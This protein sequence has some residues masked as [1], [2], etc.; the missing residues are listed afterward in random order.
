MGVD[1]TALYRPDNGPLVRLTRRKRFSGRAIACIV[2]FRVRGGRPQAS[3][4]LA[5]A[6]VAPVMRRFR[7]REHPPL[8]RWILRTTS[9]VG[10]ALLVCAAS[11]WAQPGLPTVTITF[12]GNAQSVGAMRSESI[13]GFGIPM[14]CGFAQQG[15][16]GCGLPEGEACC[17]RPVFEEIQGV[18]ALLLAPATR[19]IVGGAPGKF[20]GWGG[21]CAQPAQPCP[22]LPFDPAPRECLGGVDRRGELVSGISRGDPNAVFG[23]RLTLPSTGNVDVIMHWNK[24]TAAEENL[25]P[26]PDIV[27][28]PPCTGLPVPMCSS[29]PRDSTAE[30]T[31][32]QCGDPTFDG[33]VTEVDAQEALRASVGG[34]SCLLNICDVNGDGEITAAD[35]LLIF[36]RAAGV[37]MEPLDAC[38]V[39]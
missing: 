3:A 16:P 1:V 38:P 9:V 31:P 35:G 5:V 20:S 24:V 13:E 23:C 37:S 33:V 25:P 6:A 26:L 28:P 22:F 11:S 15:T 4:C 39:P 14:I 27:L 34:L 19:G 18:T 21:A 36:R 17:V 29:P 2:E 12:V 32:I 10:S 7:G 8:M 30:P